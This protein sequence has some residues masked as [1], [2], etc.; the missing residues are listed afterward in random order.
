MNVDGDGGGKADSAR[1][2]E[3]DMDVVV[4]KRKSRRQEQ[5]Q[6]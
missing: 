4:G 3:G 5:Q 2:A 1:V 6:M